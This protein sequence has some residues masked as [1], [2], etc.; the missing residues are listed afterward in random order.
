M[1]SAAAPVRSVKLTNQPS[2]LSTPLFLPRGAI[3]K[4]PATP[5]A[6]CVSP[7]IPTIMAIFENDSHE[8]AL[9]TRMSTDWSFKAPHPCRQSGAILR[10]PSSII[11]HRYLHQ[12]CRS[13]RCQCGRAFKHR[14]HLLQHCVQHAEAMS[15]IC[16][17]CGE[18]FTGAN[19]LTQ[20][21][22]GK[23][24]KKSSSSGRTWKRR[25]KR[26][27]EILHVTVDNCF[28]DLLL[29]HCIILKTRQKPNNGR[30]PWNDNDK[31]L[32][33]PWL[34][35]GSFFPVFV[36]TT[37]PFRTKSLIKGIFYT[38]IVPLFVQCIVTKW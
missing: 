20:H 24:R 22:K 17:N 9:M 21:T 11:S 13:H 7:P 32:V 35:H 28:L 12:G 27:C 36:C 29:T 19:L 5:V 16:V 38:L 18:S 34:V 2:H 10:Q 4:T 23:S 25:L 1:T 33:H 31:T 30:S 3:D 26:K 8:V 37:Q 15:Y 6:H 14:L